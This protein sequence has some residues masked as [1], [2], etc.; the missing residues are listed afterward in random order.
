MTGSRHSS[1]KKTP[2]PRFLPVGLLLGLT[3]SI[4]AIQLTAQDPTSVPV[5][6]SYFGLTVMRSRVTVPF[7]Y[8]TTRV[9]DIWPKPEWDKANPSAGVYDFSSLDTYLAANNNRTR[10]VIY[11]LGKT[12]QWASSQP[13]VTNGLEPGECAPPANVQDWDNYVRAVVTHAAGRIKYWELWNEPNLATYY[14]G[15]IPSMVLLAKHARQVIKSVDPS[16][17]ILSPSGTN[18]TGPDWLSSFLAQGGSGTFDIVAFHGY[19]TQKAEDIL[20]LVAKYKAVMKANGISGMPLWDTEANNKKPQTAEEESAFLAKYFLLQWS[21][22][23]SRFLWYAY[24]AHPEWGQLWNPVTNQ[25]S[26]ASTAYVQVY[27][28]MVGATLVRPCS[29]DASGNWSC[30]FTRNGRETEALWNS[31]A[32]TSASVPPQFVEYRDLLGKTHSVAN[33]TVPVGNEPILLIAR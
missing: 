5:P 15:D 31:E 33:G 27:D 23:V 13:A 12:P 8:G 3:L 17:L 22:G 7:D 6:R 25:A 9:W 14:C 26:A 21:E 19:R 24:D 1:F 32:T 29:K 20:P 30:V 10:D 2:F 4:L 28:W 16:A 11:T 18:V